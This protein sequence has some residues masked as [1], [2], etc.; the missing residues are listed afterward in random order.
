MSWDIYGHHGAAE[1]L[2]QQIVSGNLR[3]AYLFSGPNGVGRRT[4]ALR[5]AQAVNCTH[6]PAPGEACGKCLSCRQIERMQH[7]DLAVVETNEDSSTIKIKQV[8]DLERFLSLAPY[9]SNYRIALLLHF[10][11]AN[12]SA[13]N[14]L[15]KTLEEPNPKVLLLVTTDDS[16]NLLPTITSRCELLRLRPMGIGALAKV[17]VENEGLDKEQA[18]L[19]AHISGGRVGYA[20]RLMR[21]KDLLGR[22]KQWLDD[23][24][25]MLPAGT[26]ERFHYSAK[27]VHGNKKSRIE[28]KEELTEGLAYW[29]SFW[30]DVML[31]CTDNTSRITNI[32][33]REA[34]KSAAVS[35]GTQT[36]IKAVSA[37]EH[38]FIRMQSAN[39]QLMLDNILLDW[40][41]LNS[42]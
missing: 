23:L 11:E 35:V 37:L 26:V 14:A 3:H 16:E 7:A 38:A 40:P 21:D 29:L 39:L 8:R 4:L 17:L 27:A 9:A 41:R 28:A 6:P 10:E 20:K 19:T 15:L 33:Y 30:R 2:Q 12:V 42:L 1:M 18:E 24:L 36:A 32:D 22:R 25:V 34:I 31:V 13:Q 5:L